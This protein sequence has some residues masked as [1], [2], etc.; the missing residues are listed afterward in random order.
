MGKVNEGDKTAETDAQVVTFH[1]VRSLIPDSQELWTIGPSTRVV[2]ALKMM[3]KHHYSQLP[4]VVGKAVLGIFSYRSFSEKALTR[5]KAIKGEWLGDQPVED[6]LEEYEFVHGS[7][8]WNRIV[9]YLNRD[10]A[11]FVG[12]PNGLDGLVTTMDVLDYFRDIASP[13]IILAEIELSLRRV[14]QISVTEAN[15]RTALESSLTTAY[16]GKVVPMDL[17]DM[18]FDNYVQIISNNGNWKFFETFFDSGDVSRKQTARKLQQLRDWRN[19]VFHFKRRLEP[20]ELDTLGEHRAWLQRR[21]RAYEAHLDT[22]LRRKVS[23]QQGSMNR[24]RFMAESSPTEVEFYSWLFE[25]VEKRAVD[26]GISWHKKSFSIR[27]RS[28]QRPLSFAYGYIH[29]RFEIYFEYLRLPK[30]EL[31][32]LR[33]ALLAFGVF[34][35]SGKHSLKVDVSQVNGDRLREACR[36]LLDRLVTWPS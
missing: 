30:S 7:Q 15:W 6:F 35:E 13:F 20:W 23:P 14:I 33:R 31:A 3:Q 4:V 2:D 8:D 18:T 17:G 5:Q 19:I 1:Q 29:D 16:E 10:D 32:D 21:M 24:G 34:T 27:L 9:D 28:G 11:F 22:L 25:A 12:H 36:F 26:Y